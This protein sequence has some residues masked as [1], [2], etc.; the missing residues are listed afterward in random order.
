MV[1]AHSL[2]HRTG[3][4]RPQTVGKVF[5]LIHEELIVLLWVHSQ[6]QLVITTTELGVVLNLKTS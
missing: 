6:S 1:R 4:Q 5:D 2:I 3:K